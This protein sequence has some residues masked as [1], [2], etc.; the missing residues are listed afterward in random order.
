M[1]II[2]GIVSFI[3]GAG[4]A[5]LFT[6]LYINNKTQSSLAVL[7]DQRDRLEQSRIQLENDLKDWIS[8]SNTLSSQLATKDAT[9]TH[10]NEK[11]TEEKS[12]IEALNQRMENEFKLLANNILEEKSKKFVEANDQQLKGILEPLKERLSDYEKNI[13]ETHRHADIERSAMKEQLKMMTE[14]N[15]KMSQEALNLTKALKGDTKTQGN[16]GELILEKILEKSGLTKGAEY[17]VQQSFTTEDGSKLMPDVLL[18]LPEDK[19]IIIDSKVSL[20]AYERFVSSEDDAERVLLLK[21]HQNSLRAHVKN[22]SS[23]SYQQLYQIKT[24]D[25]VLLFVPIE[26]AFALAIKDNEDL[27][28]EAFDKNIII[29]STSTLL[30][31]LRTIANIWKQENQTQNAMEIARQGADLYD[32]FV[33]F[34]D[35]MV[36]VGNA[37][38]KSKEHYKDAMNKLTQGKGNLINRTET[39]KKLGL[40]ASKSM[41]QNILDRSENQ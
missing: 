27:Y 20:V 32:K 38:E 17:T 34:V 31:T 19:H 12:Q 28:N 23:K 40:K 36:K 11:I 21:E 13:K 8:K 29:V 30:A 24:L 18:K 26:S 5:A 37:M 33:G 15:A 16:W 1:E 14:M 3:I 25:F 39:M 4:L 35:D 22:L 10:L 41:P 6:F 2:I 7:T 9:I